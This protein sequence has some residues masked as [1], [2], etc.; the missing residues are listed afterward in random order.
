MAMAMMGGG[1]P[2]QM[3]NP[4]SLASGKSYEFTKMQVDLWDCVKDT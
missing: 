1:M 3:Q 4:E 2:F